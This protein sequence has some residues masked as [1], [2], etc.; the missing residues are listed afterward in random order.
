MIPWILGAVIGVLLALANFC[1]SV[2]VSS[3]AIRSSKISSI[4]FVLGTF[5]VRLILLFLAFYFLARVE[6]VQLPSA[7]VAF[8]LCFTVLIFWEMRIYYRKA[9]FPDKSN[10]P[11][12]R[13]R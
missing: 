12:I 8:T 13:A 2:A 6:I 5:F 1:A 9:R 10:L 7:L 11:G 4:A 3:I